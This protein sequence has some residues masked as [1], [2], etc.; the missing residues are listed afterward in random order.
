MI[1]KATVSRV[2]E[3]FHEETFLAYAVDLLTGSFVNPKLQ[4]YRR[5]EK[6]RNKDKCVPV[7]LVLVRGNVSTCYTEYN[8]FL[9]ETK[10]NVTK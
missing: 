2:T 7:R 6:Y 4:L 9:G 3:K 10:Q 8:L 5:I 1:T